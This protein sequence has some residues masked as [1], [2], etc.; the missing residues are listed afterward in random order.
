MALRALLTRKKI[1][2]E[3]KR[4][5]AC[6]AKDADFSK[7]EKELEKAINELGDDATDEERT[8]VESEVDALNEEKRAND[9]EKTKI[10][11]A[12]DKL[13]EIL[14]AEEDEQPADD[15]DGATPPDPDNTTP[16]GRKKGVNIMKRYAEMSYAERKAFCEI[17]NV[18]KFIADV[19][20]IR[21]V[22]GT[23]VIIPEEVLPLLK[24]TINRYSKLRSVVNL[25]QIGGKARV[26]VLGTIP[27]AVWTEQGGKINELALSFTQID[28]DGYKVAGFIPVSN[29]ILEDNDVDLLGNIVDAIG[30]AIG[31]ALDKAI[32]FGDGEKKPEGIVKN[33]DEGNKV[34][35]PAAST[36]A[37]FFKDFLIASGKA[38]ANYAPNNRKIWLMNETT[39]TA[40]KAEALTFNASGAIVADV[41]NV[42]PVIG[43]EIITLDFIKD[44]I[45]IG[46]YASMYLLGERKGA[47]I[48]Q[49]KEVKF[50]EDETVIK[51]TARY[52]G[53]VLKKEA[54]V[55][56][57]INGATFEAE[58]LKPQTEFAEDTA[59]MG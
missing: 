17:E 48:A 14:D 10:Q 53:K 23:E 1:D 27:E 19:R 45:I 35:I 13:Q 12:I 38:K 58:E 50:I 46:G 21:A 24:D 3:K 20:N 43:G 39:L 16:A 34:T 18:R 9:E 29:W 28:I 11:E 40:V 33:L 6:R 47:A 55:A 57:G 31:Y 32:V 44:N 37:K 26:P 59:N 41:N 54:F 5:D 42:M 56:I 8:A 15:P 7:R 25:K 49:S 2:A 51:G 52:D 36:G 4:L 22:T 30:Q